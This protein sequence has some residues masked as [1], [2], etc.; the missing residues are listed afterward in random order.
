MFETGQKLWVVQ[1]PYYNII[2]AIFIAKIDDEYIKV[3][4]IKDYEYKNK[5]VVYRKV[6]NVNIF[7]SVSGA[8]DAIMNSITF[9][10]DDMRKRISKK[11]KQLV[12]VSNRFTDVDDYDLF[13]VIRKFLEDERRAKERNK[14]NREETETTTT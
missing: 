11:E 12:E 14:E 5:N 13:L 9:D 6:R 4:V 1:S 3:A 8:K 10:I 7:T 2:P